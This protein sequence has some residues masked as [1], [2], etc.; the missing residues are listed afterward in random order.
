MGK[1]VQP[2]AGVPFAKKDKSMSQFKIC[3]MSGSLRK[4]SFNTAALR[5][6]Q[7][8]APAGVTVE[9]AD[10][11]DIPLYDEDLRH[12]GSFPEPV[13]R[14]RAQIA[15]ADGILFASPEYNYSVTGVLKN[16]IDWA[17]RPANQPFDGKAYAILGAAGG[18]L[19]TSRGQWHLRQIMVG[20]NAWGVNNPQVYIGGAA[21]KFDA[22][23]RFTDEPGRVLI[24]QL[25]EALVK[26]GTKL[27]A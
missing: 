22:E 24:G 14:L 16:A 4:N 15:A 8:L 1:A 19:G 11:S 17:S 25:L 7:E 5:A 3:A 20:C 6:A 13:M 26:L 12:E 23:G 2:P 18:I 10:L 27:K 21:Q 9:I